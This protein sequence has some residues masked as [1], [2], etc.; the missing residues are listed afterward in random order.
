MND[1]ARVTIVVPREQFSKSQISRETVYAA[2]P[3]YQRT[4]AH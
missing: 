1:N 2:T 3:R 4:E